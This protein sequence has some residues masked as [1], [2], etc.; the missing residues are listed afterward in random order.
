VLDEIQTNKGNAEV[1]AVEDHL[2]H[3]GVGDADRLEDGGAVV[4]ELCIACE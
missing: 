3:K 1:D 2:R 4:E